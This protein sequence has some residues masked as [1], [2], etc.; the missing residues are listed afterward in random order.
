MSAP[1]PVYGSSTVTAILSPQSRA[2][3]LL[4]VSAIPKLSW[5]PMFADGH[6]NSVVPYGNLGILRSPICAEK[7]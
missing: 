4:R 7:T 2:A 1:F 5:N 6:P 3:D